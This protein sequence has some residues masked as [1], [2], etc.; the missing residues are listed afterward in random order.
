VKLTNIPKI[1]GYRIFRDFSWPA[2]LSTF[3]RYNLIFA[4]NGS[5]KTTLSY[6][7]H[8]IE[9]GKNLPP[10]EGEAIFAFDQ[11]RISSAQL[12]SHTLPNLRGFNRDTVKRSVFEGGSEELTPVFYLGE[13]SVDKQ[14]QIELLRVE[15]AALT[16]HMQ[17]VKQSLD[18]AEFGF[19]TFCI[20]SAKAIKNLLT[21]SGSAFNNYDKSSF[22]QMM[23]KMLK[24][25]W[26]ARSFVPVRS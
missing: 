13:D 14:K 15:A 1:K 24:G 18:V 26:I 4:A 25:S 12:E 8:L 11:S 9:R 23:T 22:K 10:P 17:Q 20:S 5:G 3:G 2:D 16:A 19:D 7:M 21:A 6:L